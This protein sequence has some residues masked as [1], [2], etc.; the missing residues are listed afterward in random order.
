MKLCLVMILKNA[1]FVL[2][3]NLF[4]LINNFKKIYQP[5]HK[6]NTNNKFSKITNKKNS[7]YKFQKIKIKNPTQGRDASA[8]NTH[9]HRKK[10]D[11]Y[12]L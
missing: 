7:H 12:K 1:F 6:N 9:T 11:S 10:Y 8:I 3:N 5:W 2:N 4:Y